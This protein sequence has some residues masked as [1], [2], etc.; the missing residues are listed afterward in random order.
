MKIALYS[1]S[2]LLLSQALA[3]SS[4]THL[5]KILKNLASNL[6]KQQLKSFKYKKCDIQKEKWALLLAA[7]IPF[8]EKIKFSKNCNLQ[9]S[10]TAKMGEFFPFTLQVSNIDGIKKISG[11]IKFAIVFTNKTTLKIELIKAN[12]LNKKGKTMKE[13]QIAYSFE[14]DPLDPAN[15]IKRD[16]G[17]K[18]DILSGGKISKSILL[19]PSSP[20]KL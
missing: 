16:L 11:K 20:T 18:L 9:G 8:E 15:I 3:Y 14:I 19:T 5:D 2:I 10:F 7:Q 13:F 1:L 4:T 17:G 12:Y 6:D